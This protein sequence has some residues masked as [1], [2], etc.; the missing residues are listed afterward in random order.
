VTSANDVR[1][2]QR[3]VLFNGNI[4]Y[5]WTLCWRI[6][7]QHHA[8][9]LADNVVLQGRSAPRFLSGLCGWRTPHRQTSAGVGG[10]GR[11]SMAFLELTGLAR[12]GAL[13]LGATSVYA[14][15]MNGPQRLN[16]YGTV[17]DQKQCSCYLGA[18]SLAHIASAAR[19][20]PLYGGRLETF[21]AG[22]GTAW[23]AA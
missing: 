2:L 14:S 20:M 5:R 4:H 12:D 9:Q 18:A 7:L 19:R 1:R 6:I 3:A 22:V 17:Y 10:S 13:P 23:A 16:A 15:A 21:G 11:I 8:R